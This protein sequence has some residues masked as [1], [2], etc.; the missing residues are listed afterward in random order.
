MIPRVSNKTTFLGVINERGKGEGEP[1]KPLPG[2]T[3]LLI[4]SHYVTLTGARET[5]E[6]D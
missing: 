4:S 6:A 5:I 3:R 2:D 1:S